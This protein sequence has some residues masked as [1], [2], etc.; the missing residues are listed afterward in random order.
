MRQGSSFGSEVLLDTGSE[1]CSDV[2]M[3]HDVGPRHLISNW[4]C[5]PFGTQNIAQV[6]IG[7]LILSSSL[8]GTNPWILGSHEIVFQYVLVPG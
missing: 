6:P 5:S 2:Y 8:P 4:R 7:G 1:K 3:V